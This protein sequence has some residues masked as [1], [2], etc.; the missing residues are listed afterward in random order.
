M[1]KAA[2]ILLAKH[3]SQFNESIYNNYYVLFER[4]KQWAQHKNYDMKKQAYLTLDS[5]YI[6]M[7]EMLK[8]KSITEPDK[9]QQIFLFFIKKFQQDLTSNLDLKETVI[10]IKGFGA[11]AGPCKQ[12]MD[13]KHVQLMFENI[14]I[15]CERTFFLNI[16][17]EEQI[18]MQQAEIFDE[19]IYQLPSF[20]E[21]LSCICNQIDDINESSVNILEKLVLLAIDSYPKLIKRYNY[22]ISL[23][24]AR[25]FISIQMGSNQMFYSEFITKIVYQSMARIFSY[26]TNYQLEEDDQNKEIYNVTSRDY[27][28]LWSNLLNLNEFKELSEIGIHVDEKKKL[29]QIL[30]DELLECML[31]IMKKLDLNAVKLE[32]SD[33]TAFNP[34][35]T[36]KANL[37]K[38]FE[39][40]VNLV[41]FAKELFL[42]KHFNLFEKWIYKFSKEIIILS[43]NNVLIS[44]FYKLNSLCMR[45]AIKIGYF[46]VSHFNRVHITKTSQL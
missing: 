6:Q 44:G 7:A 3:A 22:Q 23:A 46:N 42:Q 29:I 19:K 45:I 30:Y 37:P 13:I 35:N 31:K 5:Y 26:K 38:N 28:L 4:I 39:I 18:Q 33:D 1:P 8:Q 12:F 16:Q 40:L 11:F 36:M 24:I 34:M 17:Q 10:A 25:L 14:L 27:I 15:I 9:C 41:D 32:A 43:S 20:I 21:S 2:L